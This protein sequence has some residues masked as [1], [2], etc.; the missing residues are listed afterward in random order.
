MIRKIVLFGVC[1]AAAC[2]GTDTFGA[3]N[4]YKNLSIAV[5]FRYQETQSNGNDTTQ[6]A[7][8]WAN[9]EK[10]VH[11][12]KVY[13]E[14]TRNGELATEDAVRN[15]KKFFADRG[16][17]TSGALGLTVNEMNGFQTFCY[18]DP[19]DR[20]KVRSMVQF[21]A[22]HFDEI[23]LDDFFFNNSK[24]DSDITAKGDRSWT[25]F[26]TELMAEVS[27]NLI[28][29]PA[30][31]VNPKVRIII[32]YP[33]WYESF[34]ALGY[35]LAVQP[36]MF[37]AIYTGTETR[38]ADFG[39]RLQSYQSYLQTQYFN[40]IK[41][42]G[43]QGG[44][45]DGGT[46]IERYAEQF[47]DTFFAKVREITLFNSQQITADIGGRRGRI[48]AETEPNSSLANLFAPIT[49]P[50]ESTYQ[51]RNVARIAGY[52]AEML[53]R[54]LGKLGK[55]VGIATYKP[56][57][58]VGEEYLPTFFGTIGIP[59]DLVPEFPEQAGT[60]FLTRASAADTDL[61]EKTRKFVQG[62]GQAIVTS[63]LVEALGE[64][65]FQDIAE[66]AV[67]GRVMAKDFRSGFGFFGG[68]GGS[69]GAASKA[70]AEE[71]DLNIML[72][73]L[74]HFENDTWNSIVFNTAN[75]GYP[76]VVG[77]ERSTSYGKGTFYVI[78]I[79]DD[80][81]DL[82]RLPEEALN[83][84]RSLFNR[85]MWVALEAPDHVSLFSYDNR[86]FIV[87]NFRGQPVD[88]RVI[89]TEAGQI[90]DL[91][92][93][94]LISGQTEGR[95]RGRGFGGPMMGGMAGRG[96][97]GRGG[98]QASFDVTVPGHSFRVFSAE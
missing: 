85:N 49:L 31:E 11:V 42:G 89:V 29:E 64:N 96:A 78:A 90:R 95:G 61:V 20:E 1:L 67:T 3:A 51:P 23:I 80:F 33:N 62:G 70:Q 55:P 71:S 87:Q 28:L 56:I 44:W 17:K 52:S 21:T 50:D 4:G 93:G 8:Q 58:S 19:A 27:K 77:A 13:L 59:M 91:L 34:Q 2:M 60:V 6:L 53:D 75:F 43:N 25:Q 45:I 10:Q 63:G 32:K 54:F 37:D 86:T 94:L 92:T 76:M 69:A 48:E 47:W 14:T 65:G 18:T 16:I 46:D 72:P 12:D 41:P 88:T 57:N 79:P 74:R 82:Y 24:T 39:Q 22:R 98:S 5:Y 68:F 97:S 84:I 7:T 73:K 30:K 66:I 9:I 40:N 15:L 35:D 38:N 26:R 36:K 83:Q 81:A